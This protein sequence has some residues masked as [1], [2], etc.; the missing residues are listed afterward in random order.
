MS[1]T[2]PILQVEQVAKYFPLRRGFFEAMARTDAANYVRALE[3][4]SFTLRRGQSLGIVGET[5]CG[6]TTLVKTLLRLYEPSQGRVLFEGDDITHLKG[7]ALRAFRRR[8]Q[9]IFQD[10]FESL[11]PRF[12]IGQI[13]IEPLNVHAIGTQAERRERVAAMLAAMGL[14]T[15]EG[16]ERRYPHELSG[17]QRQRVAIGRA[18]I[19]DPALVVAD[20]PVSML[21]VSIRAGLIELLLAQARS[22]NRASIYVSHDLSIIRYLCDVTAVMYLGRVVEM[23]PTESLIAAPSHPYTR[24]LV[25]A[26]PAPDPDHKFTISIRVGVPDATVAKIGCPF[27]DRCP[28]RQAICNEVAPQLQ[29][30]RHADGVTVACHLRV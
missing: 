7:R 30:S 1:D 4:V 21:D 9:M 10:P 19:T 2:A 29:A 18:L 5:G 25:A 24:A 27:Y 8:A 11:N 22:G 6:K 26:V 17:G 23:G 3:G 16:M 20:E 28:E 13:L 12:T 15:S 14:P